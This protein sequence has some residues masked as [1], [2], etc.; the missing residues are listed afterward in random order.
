MDR[1]LVLVA[2]G[3]LTPFAGAQSPPPF[4]LTAGQGDVGKLPAGWSAAQTHEGQAGKWQVVADPGAPSGSGHVLAQTGAAARNVFNLCVADQSRFDRNL[5]LKL[6]LKAVR[7]D[8]DQGGGP[9]WLYQDPKN[10]YVCRYNPL[11]ENFRLYHLVNGKRTQLA[12]KEDV[13]AG[14]AAWHAIEV[15]HAGDRITC[16]LDGTHR[17]EV[18]DATLKQ[19]GKVGLWTKADAHTRFD[20]FEA[21]PYER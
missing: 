18:T 8:V 21:S 15:I 7:G 11:E 3:L 1:A 16:I 13:K 17:L 4:R 5:H 20:Q 10:Y 2:A 12:T 14:A 19:P 6:K 9:V